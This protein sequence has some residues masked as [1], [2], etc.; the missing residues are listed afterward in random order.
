M[1][2]FIAFEF[3]QGLFGAHITLKQKLLHQ[4]HSLQTSTGLIQYVYPVYT[5]ACIC[6]CVFVSVHMYDHASTHAHTHPRK[7]P[8]PS[9]PASSK[10][11]KGSQ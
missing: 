2:E 5:C 8:M 9:S 4:F 6:E 3:L 1:L 7:P 10:H 11:I